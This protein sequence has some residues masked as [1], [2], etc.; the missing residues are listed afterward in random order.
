MLANDFPQLFDKVCTADA[1]WFSLK[2]YQLHN[3]G[4]KQHTGDMLDLI[5]I[6]IHPALDSAVIKK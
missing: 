1:L 2:T 6:S 4:T 5:N 3:T